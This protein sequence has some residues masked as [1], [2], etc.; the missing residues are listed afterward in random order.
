MLGWNSLTRAASL[1]LRR[2]VA[3]M[4]NYSKHATLQIP[5]VFPGSRNTQANL[6]SGTSGMTDSP[7][8]ITLA[9]YENVAGSPMPA[10]WV[11]A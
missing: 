8:W 1:S 10:A 9:A 5:L 11:R 7:E 2:Y 6:G 3:T 4:T